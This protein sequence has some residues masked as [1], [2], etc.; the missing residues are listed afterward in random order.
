VALGLI[1]A[2]DIPEK[3]AR[4]LATELPDLLA[5]H[6][7]NRVSWDV[8]VVVD[9]VTGTEREAPEILDVCH[10]RSRREGWDLAVCLTDLPVYRNG[11]LV[12]A[13]VSV[14]RR[15]AVLSLP[16]LGTTR[17]RPR[18]REATL[19][20]VGELYARAPELGK[21]NPPPDD[22]ERNAEADAGA[23]VLFSSRPPHHLVGQR[24][25]EFL[26]PFR[27]VE[28]PNEDMKRTNVDVRFAAPGAR[29]PTTLVRNGARQPSMEALIQ[30]QG[31]T[32]RGVRHSRLRAGGPHYLDGGRRGR[33][34]AASGVM[35]AAIVAMVVW[36]IVAHHLW[37]RPGDRETRH[38]AALYNG[39]TALTMTVAVVFAYAVLFA[40]VLL[41]AGVFVPGVY[42]QS[43]LKHPVGLSDYVTLAWMAASLATVAGA[44]GASLEHEDKVREAAYGYR[45]RRRQE[46]N[47]SEE[48]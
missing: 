8:S 2:P 25:A 45:Q 12:V 24:P 43:T 10:E 48:S 30:L 13:D 29:P 15:V 9:P 5:R 41:A 34:G 1:A 11:Q 42:F 19:Q 35:V 4:E 20:L 44:L 28:P 14:A 7:D 39:V 31:R 33:L 36:I 22:E 6:V 18:A 40:L 21:D 26:A 37:E 23:P 46:A 38:W 17:L 47:E 16:I 32:R 27:R 3:I